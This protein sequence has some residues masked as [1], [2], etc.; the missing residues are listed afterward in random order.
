[1]YLA[2]VFT[3]CIYN[4]YLY[5]V[6]SLYTQKSGVAVLPAVCY[7]HSSLCNTICC[8]QTDSVYCHNVI[9]NLC[10]Y[11]REAVV[12]RNPSL[13]S[14]SNVLC[15]KHWGNS[16]ELFSDDP[17]SVLKVEVNNPK[18]KE[19]IHYAKGD[20]IKLKPFMTA[21]Q[22]IGFDEKNGSFAVLPNGPE[23]LRNDTDD[24][25]SKDILLSPLPSKIDISF[26]LSTAKTTISKKL[27]ALGSDT[28]FPQNKTHWN[29]NQKKIRCDAIYKSYVGN[30]VAWIIHD[31][32]C[33]LD[34]FDNQVT[35]TSFTGSNSHRV[36]IFDKYKKYFLRLFRNEIA[37]LTEMFG[38]FDV[39]CQKLHS[40]RVAK[41]RVFRKHGCWRH[42]D[43][44]DLGLYYKHVKT[45]KYI[46]MNMSN[47]Y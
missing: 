9:C 27:M 25:D 3:L 15:S 37:L 46:G 40:F 47:Y 23:D 8:Y 33:N 31:K 32:M 6:L 41:R 45:L 5:F 35:T 34:N 1:M 10:V 24:G 26:S 18:L 43:D 11:A 20:S 38:I 16:L 2:F 17:K 7:I 19:G 28:K 22:V 39:S 12:K 42:K 4:G 30:A 29:H 36:V 13:K 44:E 14:L 21:G